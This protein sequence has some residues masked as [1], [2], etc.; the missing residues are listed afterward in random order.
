MKTILPVLL[1]QAMLVGSAAHAA[2]PEATAGR[3]TDPF[4]TV[5]VVSSR[6]TYLHSL[7]NI[8]RNGVERRDRAG[9]GLIISEFDAHRLP[10]ASE[11]IHL[12]ERRCGGFFAFASRAEAEA[13]VGKA[14]FAPTAGPAPVYTIDNQ[15]TVLPWLPQVREDRIHRAIKRLSTEF[16][17]R[18]Y[19][20]AY[21]LASSLSV[22]D[23]WQT[24]VA[25]RQDAELALW[26]CDACGGQY[27]VV[28][29][30]HGSES[31]DEIVVLGAHLDSI[32]P[33][34]GTK[35]MTAPGADDDASGV[36]TLTEV[37]RVATAGG[38]KPK[39]TVMFMAYAAEE[40]G[41]RGSR[42][43]AQSFQNEGRKVVGVLQLDM[44]NYK[45]GNA[46]DLRLVTDTSDPALQGFVT[47]LFDE[48]LGHAGPTLGSFTCGYGCSD[49]ASWT[50]S[51]YPSAMLF[52]GGDE[53]GNYFPHIHSPHD[54]LQNMSDTASPSVY[55]AQMGLAFL[56]ELAKTAPAP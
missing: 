23:A 32:S 52:E 44:T 53:Q 1:W 2:E 36:A 30:L 3:S 12:R 34:G 47:A 45:T 39:R 35:N 54:T 51:G 46:P 50:I 48:Y 55:F 31:P 17:N 11:S 56:G 4:E 33:G 38:W 5:Y 43:I 15:A 37:L 18:Y 40:V 24:I 21:A 28:L 8:A 27:S 49:H 14:A 26:P 6:D 19:A 7:R 29:S 16:P 25:G 41:L 10:Q 20:G 42:A 22:H 9:R 13:F